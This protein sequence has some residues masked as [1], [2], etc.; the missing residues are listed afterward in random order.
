M[1][2]VWMLAACLMALSL[3]P[4]L[5]VGISRLSVS[6]MLDSAESSPSFGKF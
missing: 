3:A 1:G 5:V 4:A 6:Y 2:S